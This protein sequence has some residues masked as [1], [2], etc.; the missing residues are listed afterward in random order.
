[1]SEKRKYVQVKALGV[2]VTIEPS[3]VPDWLEH[4][5]GLDEPYELVEVELSDEEVAAMPDFDG[6]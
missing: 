4:E 5:V 2:T 1:M 3:E 6:Y